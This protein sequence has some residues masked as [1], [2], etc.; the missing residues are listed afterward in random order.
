MTYVLNRTD[1]GRG[2]VTPAGS[3]GS[4]TAKLQDARLFPTREAAE[5]ER[6]VENEIVVSAHTELRG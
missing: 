1:Q 2:Y 5:A 4:Y 6:C 3:P